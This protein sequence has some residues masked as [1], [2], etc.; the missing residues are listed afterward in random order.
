VTGMGDERPRSKQASFR[1]SVAPCTLTIPMSLGTEEPVIVVTWAAMYTGFA[2]CDGHGDSSV[3]GGVSADEGSLGR[4]LHP[5][6]VVER[7]YDSGMQREIASSLSPKASKV[8]TRIVH[9]C[10][11]KCCDAESIHTERQA[12][13]HVL[14]FTHESGTRYP[15]AAQRGTSWSFTGSDQVTRLQCFSRGSQRENMD[16]EGSLNLTIRLRELLRELRVDQHGLDL[17]L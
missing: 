9:T 10:D 15:G 14:Q 8:T 3:R 16:V 11:S 17:I 13:I 12:K 4:W 1:S 6:L 7:C 2:V 5:R